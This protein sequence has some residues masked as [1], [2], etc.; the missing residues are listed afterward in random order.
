MPEGVLR[1]DLLLSRHGGGG[2]GQALNVFGN[3]DTL[4]LILDHL[5]VPSIVQLSMVLL[6][7]AVHAC[8]QLMEQSNL[9]S[10]NFMPGL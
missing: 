4:L 10:E 2:Q 3:L 7:L 5:E 9:I 6:I 8:L 1:G